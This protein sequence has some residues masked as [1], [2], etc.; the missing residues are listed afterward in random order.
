MQPSTGWIVTATYALPPSRSAGIVRC[1]SRA[2]RGSDWSRARASSEVQITTRLIS[3]LP[4]LPPT[5]SMRCA[6]HLFRLVMEILVE[7]VGASATTITSR[8]RWSGTGPEP[9]SALPFVSCCVYCQASE[10][11]DA[12][13]CSDCQSAHLNDVDVKSKSD[14]SGDSFTP[15]GTVA[16]AA[17]VMSSTSMTDAR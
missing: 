11:M 9:S 10:I 4:S 2:P 7:Q 8:R 1:T 13:A 5:N 3:M 16:Y 6:S 17:S 12:T 14:P 15:A